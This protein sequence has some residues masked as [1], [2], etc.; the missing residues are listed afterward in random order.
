M[1]TH[2]WRLRRNLV[3]ERAVLTTRRA[4]L[5]PGDA[6]RWESDVC[7]RITGESSDPLDATATLSS[8]R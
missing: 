8:G 1:R 2:I 3:A 4:N 6:V 5:E 7:R